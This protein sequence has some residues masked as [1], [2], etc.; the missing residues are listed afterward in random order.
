MSNEIPTNKTINENK[1]RV[2]NLI[3]KDFSEGKNT[4]QIT[5][6]SPLTETEAREIGK[7]FKKKGYYVRLSWHSNDRFSFFYALSVSKL[8]QEQ[9]SAPRAWSELL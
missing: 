6:S 8:P 1:K 5:W 3:I 2:I 4:S 7:E 9:I